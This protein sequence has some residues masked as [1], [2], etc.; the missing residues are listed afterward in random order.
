MK[1]RLDLY[2]PCI[3]TEIER[4][5]NQAISAYFKTGKDRYH[6]E[7]LTGLIKQTLKMFDFKG[8]RSQY[9][10]LGGNTNVEVFL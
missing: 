2:K 3:E 6:L 9:Q 8:L 4:K 5:Y 7:S 10:P 1:I